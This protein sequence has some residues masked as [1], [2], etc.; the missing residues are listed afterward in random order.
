MN[1]LPPDPPID[2]RQAFVAAIHDALQAALRQRARQMFWVDAD[3]AD[4]PLDDPLALQGLTDW[5]RLPQRHLLLLS[6]QPEA[7]RPRARF[8]D[9][10]RPW[11]H[12]IDVREPAPEEAAELPTLLLVE[13]VSRLQLL[14]KRHW[15][16]G[17]SSTPADLQA[18]RERIDALLQ[19]SS[20][21]LPVTTLGL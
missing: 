20:S 10:Y 21:A 3:F 4:W 8:M 13:G 14:D 19:R 6:A 17:S 15:R 12:A 9:V 18:S 16:G 11:S 1:P 7:L 5:L 2:T